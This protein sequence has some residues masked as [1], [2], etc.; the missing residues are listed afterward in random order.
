MGEIFFFNLNMETWRGK[1]IYRF[2]FPSQ[3]HPHAN[4]YTRLGD[5]TKTVMCDRY[6]VHFENPSILSKAEREYLASHLRIVL[7]ELEG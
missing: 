2:T 3:Y 6:S 1:C 7:K 5:A 4:K